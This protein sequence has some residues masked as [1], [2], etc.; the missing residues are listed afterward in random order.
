MSCSN[1]SSVVDDNLA[2]RTGSRLD[3]V[4]LDELARVGFG[5]CCDGSIGA[6]E[7]FICGVDYAFVFLE[8]S[9]DEVSIVILS[10]GV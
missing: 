4:N 2:N 1:G 8:P 9:V 7:V 5:V 10:H 6:D 3:E